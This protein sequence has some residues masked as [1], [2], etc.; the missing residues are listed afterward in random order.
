MAPT[1]LQMRWIAVEAPTLI[2]LG[3]VRRSQQ[4]GNL[5]AA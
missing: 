4:P 1:G 5:A 3:Q 2:D